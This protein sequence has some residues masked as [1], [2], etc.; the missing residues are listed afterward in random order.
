M[1]LKEE[2]VAKLFPRKPLE[3]KQLMCHKGEI[4]KIATLIGSSLLV[5]R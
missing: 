1:N 3:T 4:I 5:K 2:I